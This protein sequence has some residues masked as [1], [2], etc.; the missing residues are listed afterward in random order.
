MEQFNQPRTTGEF[1]RRPRVPNAVKSHYFFRLKKAGQKRYSGYRYVTLEK[2]TEFF[3][4]LEAGDRVQLLRKD[5][6]KFYNYSLHMHNLRIKLIFD[7]KEMIME[8]PNPKLTWTED[9]EVRVY[10]KLPEPFVITI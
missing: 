6:P 5:N 1:G 3:G 7:Y 4:L 8:H 10:E 9:D 2:I